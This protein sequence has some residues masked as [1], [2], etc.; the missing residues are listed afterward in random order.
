[1]TGECECTRRVPCDQGSSGGQTSFCAPD[2][3]YVPTLL[4]LL[5]YGHQLEGRGVTYA[6]WW[7]TSRSG[8]A[9]APD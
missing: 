3:H 9:H 1:V 8:V 2:E 4:T 6:N 5:G 7:P